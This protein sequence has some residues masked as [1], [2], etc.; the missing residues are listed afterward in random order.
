MSKFTKKWYNFDIVHENKEAGHNLAL[1]Y[2]RVEDALTKNQTEYKRS[3]NGPWQF[4]HQYGTDSFP[5]DFTNLDL[6]D[7]TWDTIEVPSVWQLKGYSKP[8]YLA[9]SYPKAIGIDLDKVP[10]IDDAQN[11]L[12]IYR[13]TFTLPAG[14]ENRDTYIVF[15]AVKSALQLFVNG[16]EVGFS[17]GSMTPAEFYLTPY[18]QEGE[19]LI[20][21]VVFRYSD[22][23]YF[24]DQ[25]MW[26]LSGIYRE[27]YLYSEA[28]TR[29]QDFYLTTELNG[30]FDAATTQLELK[31][32]NRKDLDASLKV[33][34]SLNKDGINHDIGQA[35][36]KL[37]ANSEEVICVQSIIKNPDLW[38]AE[39][40]NL[41][42]L[43][44]KIE[45]EHGAVEYKTVR[46]GIKQVKI[47]AGIL[48]INGQK[49][50]LK[51]ANRHD[52]A[53]DNGWA[54][55]R[56]T[57]L[58]DVLILK[59]NNFN[60]VRTAHYPDDPYFYELCDEY[61]LYV[62]DECDLETHGIGMRMD[63][64]ALAGGDMGEPIAHNVFP[65]NNPRYY[66][67]VL[68]R[69]DRMILRDRHHA[70][71]FM[72][73]L[74]NESGHGEAF[75]HMYNRAKDLDPTRPVHY[76]G[77]PRLECS[78]VFSKMYLPPNAM[79]MLAKGE[80]VQ[81]DKLDIGGNFFQQTPLASA[82]F[83]LDGSIVQGRPSI[84]CEY[85]HA[86]EN[87]LG[88][89]KEYWDVFYKHD[90]IAG[91]FIWD[92]VDQ[93]I[94]KKTATG[95]QWLYGGDF[96]EDES[97]YYFCANGVIGADRSPQ[98]SLHEARRV[99]QNI[100]T[101]PIDIAAGKIEIENRYAFTRLNE[102][103]LVWRI[104]CEGD[105]VAQGFDE[106][107]DLAPL[108][109]MA[110]QIPIDT[111]DLPEGE[112]FIQL[113]FELKE[114]RLW[115]KRGYEVA[116]N[117]HLLKE[118]KKAERQTTLAAH[119]LQVV[120]QGSSNLIQNENI[121]VEV[122]QATGYINKLEIRGRLVLDAPLKPNYYRA[123]VDNDRS[124]ASFDPKNLLG[125]LEGFKLR[126]VGSEMQLISSEI[127]DED[128]NILVVN[129]YTHPL[130]SGETLLEYL[131]SP[132]GRVEV[133]HTVTPKDIQPYRI[134]MET[135]LAANYKH[136]KWY[137]RGPHETYCDRKTGADVSIYRAEIKDLEHRYMRPQENGNRTDVRWFEVSSD[138]HS[139]F[140]VSDETGEHLGFSAH[141]YSQDALDE[142]QHIH[143]LAYQDEVY[144]HIDALQC[145]VGGDLPGIAL[146]KTPYVI[147]TGKTYVQRFSI[148]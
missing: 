71:V 20:T 2:S 96:G 59:Q 134:G 73:S 37:Q 44:L 136:V 80:T 101:Y 137:G 120:K 79:D 56:E 29:I 36:V 51:G 84:L 91:G 21:A 121:C 31:L 49:V 57:Y 8:V 18:L 39:K 63:M 142:A 88:N 12:G 93:S 67:P 94:R 135:K 76:E 46:H 115:A 86:M 41:Y 62:M 104:E 140:K 97:N 131:I 113:N 117:Q 81:S 16:I 125:M 87:S 138:Y 11:E 105:L 106:H 15:G 52:F 75:E 25:D 130:H 78:D 69:L 43:I 47:E 147:A 40:P 64:S 5:D 90:N 55:P 114:D 129:R 7:S 3:L 19:N 70:S 66:P 98:P 74:G 50:K 60:A 24:E 85:S 128:K 27:V 13:K 89:F 111:I 103:R 116:R 26:F 42:D 61:G 110:Y 124:F 107:V 35:D 112:C 22:G 146:L 133:G 102:L 119:P 38:S 45:D 144:L 83:M 122:D 108:S 126:H 127:T 65:G 139:D 145:G 68:D 53:P 34:A 10:D 33:T 58:K 123:M 1:A 118:K 99:M 32:Q 4:F 143:E 54:V 30:T 141:H 9:A 132:D 100:I 48:Y 17:K 82:M 109:K 77:D 23:T 72:W 148:E 28:K 6:D 14:W 95:D 92:F